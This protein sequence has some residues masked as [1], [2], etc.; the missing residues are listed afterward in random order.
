MKLR[1]RSSGR[2]RF[3]L[4][5]LKEI[6][7]FQRKKVKGEGKPFSLA[8][9]LNRFRRLG[10]KQVA[11]R[12]PA[13]VFVLV[14]T[15]KAEA[16]F[17]L[18]ESGAVDVDRSALPQHGAVIFL[19]EGGDDERAKADLRIELPK[20]TSNRAAKEKVLEEI[21]SKARMFRSPNYPGI[22]YGRDLRSLSSFG[23]NM[24]IPGP[25]LIDHLVAPTTDEA[26]IVPIVLSDSEG[27]T[28]AVIMCTVRP[29]DDGHASVQERLQLTK[30]PGVTTDTLITD[31]AK[32]AVRK[33]R[34]FEK[35]Q[36]I[37]PTDR[38]LISLAATLP[39]YPLENEVFGVPVSNFFQYGLVVAGVVAGV[40]IAGNVVLGLEAG[41]LD[42]SASQAIGERDQ[43]SRKVN[44]TLNSRMRALATAMSVDVG[45]TV[46]AAQSVW[47]PDSLVSVDCNSMVCTLSLTTSVNRPS[48]QG[49][50]DTGGQLVSS[51]VDRESI[52]SI[53]MQAAPAGYR[54]KEVAITGDGNVVTVIFEHQNP[55]SPARRLLPH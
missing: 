39:F 54:K 43:F 3:S 45:E 49:T 32:Q 41:Y 40:S 14:I 6:R 38:D 18:R 48:L 8:S 24:V 1:A 28:I 19:F 42:I 30:Q 9:G 20:R 23:Q 29:G 17:E 5:S 50:V 51:T 13:P 2:S 4:N 7:L 44:D 55:D 22:I 27:G 25:S 36:V 12:E 35:P 10:A 33:N 46:K 47:Q 34:A 15:P 26:W 31:F 16:C 37:Q 21:N 53:L 11:T 52:S